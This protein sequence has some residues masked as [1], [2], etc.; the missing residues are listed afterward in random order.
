MKALLEGKIDGTSKTATADARAAKAEQQQLAFKTERANRIKNEMTEARIDFEEQ[1]EEI[2]KNKSGSFGPT[3]LASRKN[4]LT[5]EYNRNSVRQSLKYHMANEDFT[6][7]NNAVDTYMKD[8]ATDE[9]NEIKTFQMLMNL[10]QHNMSDS[11]KL[12]ATQAHAERMADKSFQNQKDLVE[13]KAS[14]ETAKAPSFK[15][16]EFAAATFAQRIGDSEDVLA[17]GRGKFV[18]GARGFLKSAARRQFEQAE[19][20]FIT[21]VLRRESGAAISPEE[22]KDAREVY[23]PKA[24]DDDET[25][26]NKAR[27]RAVIQ[28]GMLNEAGGATS[29]LQERLSIS[30]SLAAAEKATAGTT[31]SGIGWTVTEN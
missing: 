1:M 19:K 26:A 24:L 18:P 12:Q 22:F 11:E 31:A 29:L 14:M 17:G 20:N 8:L 27:A 10:E 30:E 28:A 13:W 3:A 16:T 7:A 21:A 25:L 4:R 5:T 6:A 9:A 2:E 23:I 15:P